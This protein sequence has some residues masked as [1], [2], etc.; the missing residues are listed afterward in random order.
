MR[1]GALACAVLETV[2]NESSCPIDWHL[3]CSRLNP[4]IL[5]VTITV[6]FVLGRGMVRGRWRDTAPFFKS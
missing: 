3:K 6:G 4:H 1:H 2:K 5:M